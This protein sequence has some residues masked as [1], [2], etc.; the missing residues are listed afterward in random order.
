MIIKGILI[1]F[2]VAYVLLRIIAGVIVGTLDIENTAFISIGL[3]MVS[4]HCSFIAFSKSHR[5]ILS[6]EEKKKVITG[7]VLID[8]F[9][10]AVV[11]YLS[12]VGSDSENYLALFIFALVIVALFHS[13][14]IYLTV[15]SINKGLLKHDKNSIKRQLP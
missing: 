2:T 9:I 11:T 15:G 10:E 4:I 7:L 6:D 3:L 13:V 8:I 1:R 12:K 5:R 14:L